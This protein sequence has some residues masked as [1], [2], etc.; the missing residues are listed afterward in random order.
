MK[1]YIARPIQVR[2]VRFEGSRAEAQKLRLKRR[3]KGWVL[4]SGQAIAKGH[5]AV[6]EDR[7]WYA[8][9]P[10]DFERRFG[11]WRPGSGFSLIDHNGILH[12][13]AWLDLPI[14]TAVTHCRRRIRYN[15]GGSVLVGDFRRTIG[16]PDCPGCG[17]GRHRIAR[18]VEAMK[19]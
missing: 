6:C 14:R 2:A 1:T 8:L 17:D 3:A 11:Y 10:E 13:I 15:R 12:S 9:S 19:P 16:H 18:F 5:W 7:K 4:P